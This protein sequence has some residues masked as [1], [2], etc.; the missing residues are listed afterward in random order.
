[1]TNGCLVYNAGVWSSASNFFLWAICLKISSTYFSLKDFLADSFHI[2]KN[3]SQWIT[4]SCFGVNSTAKVSSV[5]SK[6]FQIFS[7]REP[8]CCW[9]VSRQRWRLSWLWASERFSITPLSSCS[10]GGMPLPL[11]TFGTQLGRGPGSS[12]PT[13]LPR[14]TPLPTTACFRACSEPCGKQ[15]FSCPAGSGT[16]FVTQVSCRQ[17]SVEVWLSFRNLYLK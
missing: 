17:A 14:K 3:L 10:P 13:F 11:P 16:R 7:R 9:I 2:K 15:D 6:T 8:Q 12:I 5:F 4:W 1:M